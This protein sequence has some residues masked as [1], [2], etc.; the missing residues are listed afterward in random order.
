MSFNPSSLNERTLKQFVDRLSKLRKTQGAPDA[1]QWP[2][3]RAHLQE[4]IAHI[5]GFSSWHEAI[6]AVRP[7][8]K[9][10][11]DA[12]KMVDAEHNTASMLYPQEPAQWNEHDVDIFLGWAADQGASDIVFELDRPIEVERYGVSQI[13][14]RRSLNMDDMQCI[15]RTIG[16]GDVLDTN[17]HA[18]D[19]AY[20]TT[21][22]HKH[23]F[24]GNLISHTIGVRSSIQ[25]SLRALP[26]HPPTL[27]TLGVPTDA[28]E[29]ATRCKQGLIVVAGRQEEE[30]HS[31]MSSFVQQM[32]QSKTKRKV[33][34]FENPI[35]FEYDQIETCSSVRIIPVT[36]LSGQSKQMSISN[37]LRWAPSDLIIYDPKDKEIISES[38]TAA[39]TGHRV[40]TGTRGEGCVDV[41]GRMIRQFSRDQWEMR[42]V[43]IL[44]SIR[45]CIATQRLPTTRGTM[46]PIYETL[47]MDD[48]LLDALLDG[49]IDLNALMKRISDFMKEQGTDFVTAA[50]KHRDDGVISPQTFRQVERRAKQF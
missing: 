7:D 19:F 11:G 20:T 9:S 15:F 24:R 38:V 18:V 3:K 32:L 46:L 30:A 44:S 49:D 27:A 43:D 35:E 25:I 17:H 42:A 14:G 41:I 6:H 34:I 22:E 33:F 12:A 37:A 31:L 47:M 40:W 29:V 39:M 36:G 23:R 21:G 5:L 26:L 48:N 10:S 28:A 1:T 45:V 16:K 8:N 2:P 13:V 50:R 4:E